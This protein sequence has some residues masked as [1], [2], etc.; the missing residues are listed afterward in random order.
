MNNL[1]DAQR[2]HDELIRMNINPRDLSIAEMVLLG[3]IIGR[4]SD[5]VQAFLN[6]L[7]AAYTSGRHTGWG[8]S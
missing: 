1:A 2:I 7:G 3:A 6:M 8:A 5:D 4:G